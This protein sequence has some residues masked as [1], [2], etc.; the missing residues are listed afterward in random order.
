MYDVVETVKPGNPNHTPLTFLHLPSS[1]S[2]F[3]NI[4]QNGQG[5]PGSSFNITSNL[6]S[7]QKSASSNQMVEMAIHFETRYLGFRPIG[8]N[9]PPG[10]HNPQM[11]HV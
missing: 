11:L 3:L 1:S 9:I 2:I 5:N 8:G 4:Q 10:H 6:S 7:Q